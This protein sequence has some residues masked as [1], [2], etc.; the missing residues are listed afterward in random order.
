MSGW[1]VYCAGEILSINILIWENVF[2]NVQCNTLSFKC[3]KW[4][5]KKI[6]KQMITFNTYEETMEAS[7][8]KKVNTWG[9]FSPFFLTI[10]YVVYAMD[11]YC[12]HHFTKGKTSTRKQCPFHIQVLK[13]T[14]FHCRFLYMNKIKKLKPMIFIFVLSFLPFLPLPLVFLGQWCN[15]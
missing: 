3:T 1:I 8:L 15:W 11:A 2:I 9:C 10:A 12:S 14:A 13:A 5:K 4:N 7:C 6:E